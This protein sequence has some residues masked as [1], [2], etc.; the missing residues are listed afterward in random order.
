MLSQQVHCNPLAWQKV[1][2]DT[3]I[4]GSHVVVNILWQAPRHRW[5]KLNTNSSSKGNRGWSGGGGVLRDCRGLWISG[6][7][8]R[9]GFCSSMKVELSAVLHRFRLVWE[10]GFRY[11]IMEPDSKVILDILSANGDCNIRFAN[12]LA[13]YWEF[14][15]IM[16]P[17]F[18]H[19]YREAKS[20]CRQVSKQ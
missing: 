5:V 2:P 3:G 7:L 18:Y 6:F 16:T 15:A 19:A 10:L 13:Q 17:Q 4:R 20:C 11:L 14:I 1:R 8:A 12:K 9:F